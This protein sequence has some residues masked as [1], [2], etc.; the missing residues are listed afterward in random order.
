LLG[1]CG[2]LDYAGAGVLH[3]SGGVTA[4][5]V[6]KLIGPR[7]GRFSSPGL[8]FH[9]YSTLFQSVGAIAMWI[10]WYGIIL[11]SSNANAVPSDTI[12]RSMA[13]TT[14]AACSGCITSVLLGYVLNG[15]ISPSLSNG[16]VLSGLV[17]ISAACATCT[18]YGALI[19]GEISLFS[20]PSHELGILAGCLYY[21][22][23]TFLVYLEIDDVVDAIPVHMINGAWGLIAAGLFTTKEFYSEA[24][25]GLYA[26]PLSLLPPLF[27]SLS[28]QSLMI[29]LQVFGWQDKS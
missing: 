20:S 27:P 7:R 24:Y 9:E 17:A 13:S 4:F 8:H 14:I 2:V 26:R 22:S 16:G 1:G 3:L 19:I 6:S 23:S 11:G 25:S 21:T 10:G 5:I 15:F 28:P 12:S 18:M 29:A